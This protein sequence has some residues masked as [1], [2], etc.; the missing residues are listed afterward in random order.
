MLLSDAIDEYLIIRSGKRSGATVRGDDQS[1]RKLLAFV[2]NLRVASLDVEH[3]AKFFYGPNGL[4]NQGLGNATFNVHRARVNFFMSWCKSKK[5]TTKVN[6]LFDVDARA[7]ANAPERVRLTQAQLRTGLS[8]APTPRDRLLWMLPACT[9]LRAGSIQSITTQQVDLDGGWL[10]NVKVKGDNKYMSLPISDDL[11]VE[12]RRW[13]TIYQESCGPLQGEWYLIPSRRRCGYVKTENGRENLGFFRHYPGQPIAHPAPVVKVIL[14]R[15]G[16]D[17]KGEGMHTLRRSGA[18]VL[19]DTLTER[20]EG[21]AI[22]IVR[23]F[24]GHR[25]IAMT[26]HYI[27]T[28]VEKRKLE[29]AIRGHSILGFEDQAGVIDL[30]AAREKRESGA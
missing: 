3:F 20:G 30:G 1:L 5:Y 6:L 16:L 9:G 29:E 21:R 27:G 22:H 11:D 14:G 15:M 12:I 23:E 7:T 26:E 2:G 10:R 28:T 18:R 25:N 19:F 13:L 8:L 4:V 24:L 17:A